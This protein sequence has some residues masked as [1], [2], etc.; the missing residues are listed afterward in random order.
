ANATGSTFR[1]RNPSA[2]TNGG[3][4]PVG[5][6]VLRAG[7]RLRVNAYAPGLTLDEASQGSVGLV[8]VTDQLRYCAVF[9]G[10]VVRDEPG[11]FVARRAPVPGA[12]PPPV[13]VTTTTTST[14][15]PG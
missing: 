2:S 13:P 5:S 3:P 14:T 7:R 8:L 1:Y 6:A 10:M 12:C 11:R 9:G 4:S 15:L